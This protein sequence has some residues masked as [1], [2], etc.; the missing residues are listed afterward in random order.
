MN[1]KVDDQRPAPTR[2]FLNVGGG[3]K[4]IEVSPYL[5]NWRH[6]LL[7]ID[8]SV[9]PDV[10]LDARRLV[11]Q[12]PGVYDAVYCAHNLEHYYHHDAAQVARG[13]HHVLKPDGFA[14][15]RVPDLGLLMQVVVERKLDL[16]SVLYTVPDKGPILVRDVIFGYG[17]EIQQS[18]ADFY[19][20][21]TGFTTK[22][23]FALFGKSG[24]T[25]AMTAPANPVE[26]RAFFFKREPSE[27]QTSFT[28]TKPS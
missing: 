9:H 4:R 28:Q 3:D 27:E 17:K 19:A 10:C 6:D 15:V 26:I 1:A 16:D 24:F 18:G 12:P 23:L 5:K 22:S 7:D 14:E 25:V 20:H 21:K 13:F 2:A 11:E 8:P